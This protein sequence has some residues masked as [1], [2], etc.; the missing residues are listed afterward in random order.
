MK[1]YKYP[2][3]PHL[4]WSPSVSDDDIRCVDTSIFT[5]KDVIVTEKMDGENTTLYRD[6]LHA[7]SIDSRHHP[8]RDWVKKF[9]SAIAH[10]I[11][12]DWRISGENV[13]AQHSIRYNDLDSFFYGFSIWDEDNRCLSWEET[14][15][16]F[17]LLGI[18]TP[19]V[20]YHGIWNETLISQIT[21]DESVMEGYVVRTANAFHYDQFSQNIAKWVRPN[22]V[23]TDQHWMFAEIIPNQLK[24]LDNEKE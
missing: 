23:T 20:L 21:V 3:T 15:N 22:H 11:P 12:E 6:H 2:R 18:K 5:N 7:R 19:A 24:D 17:A 4:P 8:S 14:I 1:R 16:W 9:H 10:D 13:Y